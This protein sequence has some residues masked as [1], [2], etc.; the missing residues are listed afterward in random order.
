M[1]GVHVKVKVG[2]V[3]LVAVFVSVGCGRVAVFVFVGSG[4]AVWVLVGLVFAAAMFS[5]WPPQAI[6]VNRIKSIEKRK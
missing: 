3:V 6:T 1:L 5:F 4:S 2:S